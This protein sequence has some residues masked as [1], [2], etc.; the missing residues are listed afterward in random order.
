MVYITVYD[1]EQYKKSG[2]GN[3]KILL[4]TEGM[5]PREIQRRKKAIQDEW[6]VRN[7]AFRVQYRNRPVI[8]GDLTLNN[9]DDDDDNDDNDDDDNL[10]KEDETPPEIIEKI[11]KIRYHNKVT[12]ELDRNTGNT[13]ALIAS[14]KAGKSTLLMELF[15]KYYASP[16]FI[17]TLFSVNSQIE[18]Y[19]K[20]G[21][22]LLRYN[23]FD[24][25]AQ[26]TIQASKLI[27]VRT[28]NKYQF[29]FMFD[30]VLN[31]KNSRLFNNLIMT[32]RN[33]NI[34]TIICLQYTYLLSKSNRC[35]INNVLL[36][37]LN[38]DESVEDVV[39]TFLSSF[40]NKM[41]I[42]KMRDMISFYKQATND[43]G[44]IYINTAKNLIK[45]LRID[46]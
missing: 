41:G 19:R 42:L 44:F 37:R 38:S 9:P 39:K 2:Y 40:L 6:K 33:S 13:T 3:R 22:N 43:H 11:E 14:S 4:N 8:K 10:V 12:L 35:N 34:S 46:I 18:L 27:N 29:C 31:A 23:R 45:F 24:D 26:K 5:T 36:G 21:K 20:A 30:D 17:T 16:D 25:N 7:R 15:R 28:K 1:A 32:Y